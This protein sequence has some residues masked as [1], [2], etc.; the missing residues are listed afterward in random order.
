VNDMRGL[1]TISSNVNPVRAS[2]Y[3]D[4]VMVRRQV[5]SPGRNLDSV[6]IQSLEQRLKISLIVSPSTGRA[7]MDGLTNLRQAGRPH[8]ARIGMKLENRTVPL[9]ADEVDQETGVTFQVSDHL[10]VRKLDKGQ[11]LDLFPVAQ[12]P[13]IFSQSPR[14]VVAI[15][16]PRA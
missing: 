3:Y 16:V 6:P 8:H 2:D 10:F 5:A 7:R 4:Q 1:E 15:V 14:D 9:E 13:V 11:R 12:D